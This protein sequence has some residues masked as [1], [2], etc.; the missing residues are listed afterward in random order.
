MSVPFV[1]SPRGITDFESDG[2]RC[3]RSRPAQTGGQNMFRPEDN[4]E[5]YIARDALRQLYLLLLKGRVDGCSLLDFKSATGLSLFDADGCLREEL[6]PITTFLQGLR[7]LLVSRIEA[8]VAARTYEV[9][10]ETSRAGSFDVRGAP[11]DLHPSR[12]RR[13]DPTPQDRT[14]G[15]CDTARA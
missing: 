7:G 15:A 10:L 5:G 13:G 9:G 4:L 12:N 11:D 6:P 8:A 1:K 2:Q 14:Q 3:P